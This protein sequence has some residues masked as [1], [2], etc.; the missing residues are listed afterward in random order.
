MAGRHR[1][2]GRVDIRRV[3]PKASGSLSARRWRPGLT[4]SICGELI[5]RWQAFNHDHVVPMSLGGRKGKANKQLTHLLCNSVKGDRYPFSMRT[6][7]ERA[8]VR[9]W[10]KPETYQRLL[11]VW[12]G[13]AA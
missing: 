4:C 7:T 11:R 2:V 13:E 5:R 8:A 12:A 1:H 6:P 10:V 3:L 9:R